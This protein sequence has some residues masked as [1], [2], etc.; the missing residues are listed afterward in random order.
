MRD[1]ED[2][3]GAPHLP[4]THMGVQHCVGLVQSEPSGRQGLPASVLA[5]PPEPAS[6]APP[7]ALHMAFSAQAAAH[8]ASVGQPHCMVPPSQHRTSA[9]AVHVPSHST[10]PPAGALHS[11]EH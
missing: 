6:F 4:S 2:Q 3:K 9:S 10:T 1:E 5:S 11:P 8:V 7:G